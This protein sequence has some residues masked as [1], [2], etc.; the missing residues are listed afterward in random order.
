MRIYKIICLMTASAVFIGACSVADSFG[1]DKK[2]VAN[3]MK[4]PSS[5]QFRNLRRKNDRFNDH[6]I[7]CGEVNAKNSYGGYVGFV[8]FEVF[9]DA[10]K[11][12]VVRVH[13]DQ[14]GTLFQLDT[15]AM[16]LNSN[17]DSDCAN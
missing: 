15:N 5:V 4:D 14:T 3:S 9:T 7:V 17:I 16:M 8:P 10:D 11:Q 13:T 2:L 12:R 6:N 1:D